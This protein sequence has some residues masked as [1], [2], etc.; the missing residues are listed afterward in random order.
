MSSP[1]QENEP[2]RIGW[3]TIA[4]AVVVLLC[5]GCL[6]VPSSW[7]VRGEI[8]P[9]EQDAN[10]L[11]QVI[12]ALR[13][14][15]EWKDTFPEATQARDGLPPS[16]WRVAILPFLER[17]D[18]EQAYRPTQSWNQQT[19]IP[20]DRPAP[21]VYQSPFDDRRPDSPDASYV[22]VTGPET[23]FPYNRPP[24]APEEISDG[25]L[26]TI[27]CLQLP[28]SDIHWLE[29]REETIDDVLQLFK[30]PGW[31]A[32]QSGI[33]MAYADGH[34]VRIEPDIDL[35]TLRAMLTAAGGED[36]EY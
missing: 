21:E 30:N 14:Y 12:L 18:L 1:L 24:L 28:N 32:N 29:P 3:G 26:R 5:L 9:S 25:L 7:Y 19:A 11:R 10:Q 22:L 31:R 36:I 16:S 6:F 15:H 20:L 27:I 4:L 13:T 17:P 23:V 34:T 35:E 2:R 33:N 8:S